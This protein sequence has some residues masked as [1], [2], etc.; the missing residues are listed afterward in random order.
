[1]PGARP[2]CLKGPR[3]IGTLGD[4]RYSVEGPSRS[5]PRISETD[6]AQAAVAMVVDRLP[7]GCGPAFMGDAGEP[8][9]YERYGTSG[10]AGPRL[11]GN[12]NRDPSRFDDTL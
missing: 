1:M 3:T 7:P 12:G 11:G 5:S 6:S 4:G 9:A 10:R 8:A 2:Q